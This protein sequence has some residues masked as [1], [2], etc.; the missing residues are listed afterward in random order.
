MEV[1]PIIGERPPEPSRTLGIG[2]LYSLLPAPLQIG[3]LI[4]PLALVGVAI[5]RIG[6]PAGPG[7]RAWLACGVSLVVSIIWSLRIRS[8]AI[9]GSA[10]I[11]QVIR[12]KRSE[13]PSLPL[14]A[15]VVYEYEVN[16]VSYRGDHAV[17][18]SRKLEGFHGGHGIHLVV[19]P[20]S[21]QRSIVWKA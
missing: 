4:T 21:P 17:P 7:G 20:E 10:V 13:N 1:E 16:G 6:D 5:W 18:D 2:E 11:G 14:S 8:L 19:D 15:T 3:V 9:G 12:V